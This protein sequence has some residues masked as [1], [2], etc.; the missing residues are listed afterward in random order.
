MKDPAGFKWVRKTGLE[1]LGSTVRHSYGEKKHMGRPA[2]RRSPRPHPS[3][4][5]VGS[6]PGGP[7]LGRDSGVG[8]TQ[9]GEGREAG[10][11]RHGRAAGGLPVLRVAVGTR[12]FHRATTGCTSDLPNKMASP[13][14]GRTAVV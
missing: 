13:F 8:A 14:T 12:A 9:V 2:W 6:E 1:A 10:L 11:Q 4:P 5:L 7:N 3:C